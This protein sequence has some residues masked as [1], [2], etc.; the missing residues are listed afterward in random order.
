M[1][2][3]GV[4]LAGEGVEAGLL[5]QA[6]EAW[7][8]SRLLLEGEMHTLVATVLLWMPR[9]D[10]LDRNAEPESPDRQL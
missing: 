8:T 1:G 4:E 10:A 7:W 5:L 9:L 3:F 2:A 6:V